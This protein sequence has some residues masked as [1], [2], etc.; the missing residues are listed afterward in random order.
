MGSNSKGRTAAAGFAGV[1]I[2]ERKSPGI[3]PILP[4]YFH[5]QQVNGVGAIHNA[6]NSFNKEFFVTFFSFIK[7]KYVAH[8]RTAAAFYTDAE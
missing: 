4:I 5:A 7:T 2:G 1:G 3:E 8:T 6:R